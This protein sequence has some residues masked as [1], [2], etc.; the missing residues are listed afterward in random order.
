MA[1]YITKIRTAEGDLPYDYNS[2]AN[3]PDLNGVARMQ[4]NLLASIAGDGIASEFTV[5]LDDDVFPDGLY[6]VCLTV[7]STIDP[8]D[9]SITNLNQQVYVRFGGAG[10]WGYGMRNDNIGAITGNASATTIMETNWLLFVKNGIGYV[11]Q[12]N[13]HMKLPPTELPENKI[14]LYSQNSTKLT[15][16]TT[17]NVYRLIG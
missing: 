15:A 12:N 11:E 7:A 3:L 5:T 6:M 4:G 1:D 2:L 13:T 9:S 8:N 14:S 17:L 16:G 10:V